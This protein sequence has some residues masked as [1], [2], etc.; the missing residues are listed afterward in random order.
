[1]ILYDCVANVLEKTGTQASE[2]PPRLMLL[3]LCWATCLLSLH[4]PCTCHCSCG[5]CCLHMPVLACEQFMA[6]QGLSSYA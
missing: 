3:S 2:V 6:Q 5:E 4:A 1:M